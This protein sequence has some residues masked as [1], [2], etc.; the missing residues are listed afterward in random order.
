MDKLFLA[1]IKEETV[2]LDYFK[3]I[4]VGKINAT[5]NTLRLI[6]THKPKIIINYGIILVKII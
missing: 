1:A 4:G 6:N 3:H 2:G 5:Y